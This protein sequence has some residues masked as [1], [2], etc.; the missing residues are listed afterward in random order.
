MSIPLGHTG[1]RAEKPEYPSQRSFSYEDLL[2]SAGDPELAEISE[3]PIFQKE[4]LLHTGEGGKFTIDFR[5]VI[6]GGGLLAD[7]ISTTGLDSALL[8]SSTLELTII[9][10]LDQM[11]DLKARIDS[12]FEIW[13][14]QRN[15]EIYEIIYSERLLQKERKERKD[16]GMISAVQVHDK[17]LTTEEGKE[18]TRYKKLANDV[19]NE[20]EYLKNLFDTIKNRAMRIMSILNR[21]YEK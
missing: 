16:V 19:K 7:N 8:K 11:N 6:L 5:D 9:S 13:L 1:E 4:F 12:D 14:A 20:T 15:E 2:R 18:Y 17:L 3:L 21:R 10:A